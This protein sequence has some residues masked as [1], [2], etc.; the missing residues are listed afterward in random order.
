MLENGWVFSDGQAEI[1][2]NPAGIDYLHELYRKAANDYTGRATVPVLWD[3]KT[4]TIVNNE[5]RDVLRMLTTAFEPLWTRAQDLAPQARR[6]EMDALI[7]RYY[8]PVNNGVYRS[9]FARSQ[10]AYEEAVTTLFDALDHWEEHL[11]TRRFLLGDQMTEADICLFPTLIRFDAVYVTHFKCNLRRLVDYP[12]LWAYTRDIYQH[13]GVAATCNFEH[14]KS[15]Y[16]GSHASV[17]PSGVV[18]LGPL[19]DYDA[20]HDRA[21]RFA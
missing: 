6:G 4:Q 10:Q 19:L 5:S 21:T 17:N 18:P 1:G 15:H 14:I 13:P 7:E 3:R 11:S 9:G 16:F 2:N 20:R 12:N 8:T